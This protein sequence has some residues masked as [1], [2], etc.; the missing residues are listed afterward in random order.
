MLTNQPS[1]RSSR[2]ALLIG[3]AGVAIGIAVGFGA[4]VKPVYVGLL[5]GA[6]PIIFLFFAYFKQAVIVL[7]V[8]RTSLDSFS[9]QQL[10]SVYTLAI[11]ALTLLYVVVML[12][13]GRRIHTDRFW[14]F[15]AVW[16]MLQTLW[17]ILMPL[18]GLGLDASLL[19]LGI[20]EW[21]R[22]F[23]FLMIYLLVMQLKDHYHP[24]RVVS[25]LLLSLVTPVSIGI[26]QIPSG[27][28]VESTLGHPN[29]LATYLSLMMAFV[30]WKLNWAQ[31]RLPWIVLLSILTLVYV[32]TRSLAALI[33]LVVLIFVL[34][35][36]KL[37]PLKIIGAV[38]LCLIVLALFASTEAGQARLLQ[39]TQ[40]PLLNP[41]IDVSRTMIL[42]TEDGNSFN[43][44]VTHWYYLLQSWQKSPILGY[45]IGTGQYLSPLK[46]PDGNGYAP[47][48]DYIRFLVEQG[49]VGF[50]LFIAFLSAQ[51]IHL[52]GIVRRAPPN[53]AERQLSLILL[54]FLISTLVN[55]LSNNVLD[56]GD[57]WFYWWA[58]FAVAG[59]GTDRF[60]NH[61]EAI[62][63]E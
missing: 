25:L 8:V 33:T 10:P 31:R 19:P 16:V 32:S 42:A 62:Q 39:L 14:W 27:Q 63:K 34:N 24:Q 52:W 22:R 50:A 13:T 55:M 58:V 35:A 56:N 11:D 5:L 53:S 29:A 6:L 46:G 1:S 15:F 40:T 41:D 3:L 61:P 48:N 36:S 30:W 38:V 44:R 43:W 45:G 9:A 28:R 54:G 26:T 7:L 60:T 18:G 4:G 23:S 37:N 20:R 2:L 49:L 21:V 51:F 17:L 12:L 57:F 59:W 47:H